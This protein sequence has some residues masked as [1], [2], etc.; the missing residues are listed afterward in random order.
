MKRN[1]DDI[2]ASD[3]TASGDTPLQGAN[4]V[5][6]GIG[7][8]EKLATF[9]ASVARGKKETFVIR[10]LRR[11]P[12]SGAL[13]EGLEENAARVHLVRFH[14]RS[15]EEISRFNSH[16]SL[17]FYLP[18]S[19]RKSRV[20]LDRLFVFLNGFAEA[21]TDFWDGI[22]ESFARA[23]VASVLLPLPN[24]FCRNIFFNLNNFHPGD[25]YF[26]SPKADV[27]LKQFTAIMKREMIENAGQVIRFNFQ[28]MDDIQKLVDCLQNPL[29][30]EEKEICDF[31]GKHFSR[32]TRVSLMGYSLGGLC[33]LQAYLAQPERYS[34]CIL[35]N[36]GASF[37]DMD[38]SSMF[39]H[40]EWREVQKSLIQ[41][42]RKVGELEENNFFTHVILGHNRVELHEQLAKNCHKILVMVGGRDRIIRLKNMLNIEPEETGL[43]IVQIP[44][45]EHFINMRS[46]SGREWQAWSEFA[47][48]MILA[49]ARHHPPDPS[50]PPR[51]KPVLSLEM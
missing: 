19:S 13:N 32:Q 39:G 37:Q 44:G 45:L 12:L 23:G 38:A 4:L 14:T 2:R 21:T 15:R 16:F 3:S 20:R 31:L 28:L 30:L 10:S 5:R 6:P 26:L 24:H 51:P 48:Q 33:A 9:A 46:Q 50:L 35:V 8:S 49:F 18:R 17:R 11:S 7:E 42:A 43:A 36:S 47:V 41:A 34:S 40:E 25:S 22:G 1:D 27:D 29:P